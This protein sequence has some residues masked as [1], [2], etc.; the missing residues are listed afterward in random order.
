MPDTKKSKDLYLKYKFTDRGSAR[1]FD[2]YRMPEGV[3]IMQTPD[4][5]IGELRIDWEDEQANMEIP[6]E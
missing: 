6:D 2:I 5:M 1:V 3:D 4:Q